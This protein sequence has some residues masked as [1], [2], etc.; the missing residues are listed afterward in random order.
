MKTGVKVSDL[1]VLSW[2]K[3][4]FFHAI[5]WKNTNELFGQPRKIIF[6][7]LFPDTFKKILFLITK[8]LPPKKET[9]FLL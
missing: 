3:C 7:L 9:L 4:L 6:T 1:K 2:P 8:T 5:V